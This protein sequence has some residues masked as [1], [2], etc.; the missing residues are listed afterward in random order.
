MSNLQSINTQDLRAAI[1]NRTF[2]KVT[3]AINAASA[4]TIKSTGAISYSVDGVCPTAKAALSAQS[5]AI[6]HNALGIAVSA[7]AASYVQPVST[8]VYYVVALDVSGNVGVFQGTYAGQSVAAVPGVHAA[9][10]GNGGLPTIPYTYTPIGI[11][12]VVTNG[13][14]TFTAATTALDAAGVTVTYTDVTTLP[15]TLP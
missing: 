13:S 5:I 15:S 11:I 6:T 8:T 4:A 9:F 7:G 2:G 1:G 12:K 3:L 14:T 10:Y